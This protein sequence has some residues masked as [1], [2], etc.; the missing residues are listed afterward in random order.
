MHPNT[1]ALAS[2]VIQPQV[3]QGLAGV[4][5]GLAAGNQPKAVIRPFD[6]GVVDFVGADV[7]Q[8]RIPFVIEQTRFLAQGVVGPTNVQAAF[9]HLELGQH[10]SHTLG[11]DHHRGAGLHHLLDGFHARPDTC[12]TAHGDAMDAVVQYILHRRRKKHGQTAGFENMVAL[13]CGGAAFG[14][15]VIPCQGQH[16]APRR[17]ARH[18][19]VLE[20]IRGAVNARAFAVPNA[21]HP[22]EFVAARGGKSQLL[23]APQSGGGK[24]FVHTGLE[25]DLL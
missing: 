25:N 11:V 2:G 14:D 12:K 22:I 3:Q 20:H 15:V 7:S 9:G 8:R 16:T 1:D 6:N 13:V 23:R 5:V 21:K 18:I 10:N 17:G 4:V 24:L 19:G